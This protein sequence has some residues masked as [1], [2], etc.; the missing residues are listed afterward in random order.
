[1][2]LAQDA[3]VR[4]DEVLVRFSND[5]NHWQPNNYPARICCEYVAGL[6]G[7]PVSQL[8]S[9]EYPDSYNDGVADEKIVKSNMGVCKNCLRDFSL[10]SDREIW[11]I[12]IRIH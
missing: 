7:W 2:P 4:F 9:L 5:R 12:E 3:F 1:M 6:Y 11:G 8:G 10:N